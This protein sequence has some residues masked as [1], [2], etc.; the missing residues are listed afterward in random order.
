MGGG[1]VCL[2]AGDAAQVLVDGKKDVKALT[3]HLA[4]SANK[5]RRDGGRVEVAK[6]GEL[7]L[8]PPAPPQQTFLSFV[9]IITIIMASSS[10]IWA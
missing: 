7:Q 3:Q 9:V 1:H 10:T 2:V 4:D 5:V 8:P 6:V